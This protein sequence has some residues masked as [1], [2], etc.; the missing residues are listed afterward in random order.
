MSNR[1]SSLT[2]IQYRFFT[3]IA[4]MS[5]H[6]APCITMVLQW[7]PKSPDWLGDHL[8]L[9]LTMKL[10]D[11]KTHSA[12]EIME[13]S[14]SFPIKFPAH[15]GRLKELQNYKDVT[16]EYIDRNINSVYPL[17]HESV[18]ELFG[19]FLI[20]KRDHGSSIEKNFYKDLSLRDFINRLLKNRAVMFMGKYDKF[21]LITGE[22]GS[23]N[24]EK[25]GTNEEKPPQIIANCISYDEIKLSAFI[26]VSSYTYFVN[27][28]DRKNK[29][30]YSSDR[31]NI[32]DEG[33]ILGLIGPRLKKE[34]VMDF[35]EMVF[36]PKQNQAS[37]G[38]GK[39][40][41][42]TIHSLFADYF[43]EDNNDYKEVIEQRQLLSKEDSTRYTDL[44]KIG[45]DYIFDNH[46]Y[47]KRLTIIFDSLLLEADF[48]AKEVGKS[49]YVHVVGLGLGV[50][51]IS[52]HQEKVYMDCFYSRI[53]AMKA[54]I[55]NI[56]DI[57]F[58]YFKEQ[59]CG[60]YKNGQKI[61]IAEHPLQG[62]KI[63][64]YKRDPHE[65]LHGE[66]EGKLLVVTYAWD[67]NS[68]PGNEFWDGKLG[69]S[70]DSAAA[71]STQIAELHNPH[72]HPGV[73]AD[74]LRVICEDS[75][76]ILSIGEYQRRIKTKYVKINP[77][78]SCDLQ[79]EQ[80]KSTKRIKAE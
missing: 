67:G 63:H 50:W 26:Y 7:S 27:K 21:L 70:G 5:T 69:S 71:S 75:D 78:R 36:T 46:I 31:S 3:S 57:C 32:Q 4:L 73:C 79:C 25:I 58:S 16:T 54:K 72:I 59:N 51:K 74:N 15:A 40:C 66:H 37:N 76:E 45:K 52:D 30:V 62:I 61:Q 44:S 43:E 48:R 60:G 77:L 64:I 22:R 20:F 14:D 80:E 65:K 24:W 23:H 38:Y 39:L 56:S 6:H 33:V 11:V 19:K 68:M 18:L 35:Q 12:V 10:E 9:F 49:A 41:Q 17:V 28:G 42:N 53:I 1:S 8:H 13:R 47:H 55:N 34:N 29:A 2:L